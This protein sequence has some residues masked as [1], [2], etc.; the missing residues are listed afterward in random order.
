MSTKPAVAVTLAGR[1]AESGIAAAVLIAGSHGRGRADAHSDLE[2]DVYWS[3]PPSRTDRLAPI[4]AA[5]GRLGTIWPYEDNEWS[6]EFELSGTDV[7]I[8]GFT[9]DWLQRCITDVTVDADPSL[10]KQLRLAA[11]NDGIVLHGGEHVA[12][13]RRRSTRY[14]DSLAAAVAQAYLAP[15]RLGMW[16]QW[17]A[18]AAR[19]DAVPLQVACSN[20]SHAILGALSGVNRILIEHPQFKWSDQLISRFAVAP[21]DF[22]TRFTDAV[23]G[24]PADAAPELHQLLVETVELVAKRLPATELRPVRRC[25]ATIR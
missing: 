20:A 17:R 18:L 15:S 14:P 10:A 1:Y 2:I 12:R 24:R 25:L 7:T 19:E 3:R 22:A 9:A 11:L 6:E 5:G 13:W 8:S 21:Q 23:A 16:R 4:R